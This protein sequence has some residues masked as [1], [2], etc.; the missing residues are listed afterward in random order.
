MGASSVARA[1]LE[2]EPARRLINGTKRNCNSG[3][4]IA[5]SSGVKEAKKKQLLV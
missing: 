1:C 5:K 3:N 4:C 2:G